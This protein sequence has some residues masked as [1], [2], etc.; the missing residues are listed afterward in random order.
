MQPT[1]KK[2]ILL[3]IKT[4][5]AIFLLTAA[6]FTFMSF[7]MHKIY[8]DV[9]QQLGISKEKGIRNIEESFLNGAFYYYGAEKA[10]NI[11]VGD[12]AAIAKDLLVYVKQQVNSDAFKTQ[13]EQQRKNAKPVQYDQKVKT[14]EE[15]RKEKIE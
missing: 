9:W 13:Y 15:I 14:K 5:G 1:T 11:L 6:S 10:K 2:N 3:N 8:T 12:R 4:T 7:K